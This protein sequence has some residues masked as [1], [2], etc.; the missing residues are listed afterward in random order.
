MTGSYNAYGAHKA[1]YVILSAYTILGG[2]L[3]LMFWMQS[4]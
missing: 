4:I 1:K 3:Q 2:S